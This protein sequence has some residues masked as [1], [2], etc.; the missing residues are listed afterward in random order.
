MRLACNR[1]VSEFFISCCEFGKGEEGVEWLQSFYLLYLKSGTSHY[2]LF[3]ISY[4]LDRFN[5]KEF[6]E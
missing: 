4:K 5:F 3:H 6:D 1:S 2:S